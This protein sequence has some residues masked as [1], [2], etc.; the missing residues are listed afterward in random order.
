MNDG[1]IFNYNN[2]NNIVKSSNRPIFNRN[3]KIN[4]LLVSE[5]DEN[6]NNANFTRDFYKERYNIPSSFPTPSNFKPV[7]ENRG[8]YALS[9]IKKKNERDGINSKLS[10]LDYLSWVRVYNKLTDSVK[11]DINL[12]IENKSI[13]VFQTVSNFFSQ[14][15][16]ACSEIVVC[17]I[18]DVKFLDCIQV[19][20]C[21]VNFFNFR[22]SL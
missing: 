8:E 7:E 13:N 10:S 1:G 5:K 3:D 20:E 2:L 12:L 16:F 18:V 17:E 22:I 21:K 14:Y 4:N 11:I 6:K 9:L 15:L 19:I